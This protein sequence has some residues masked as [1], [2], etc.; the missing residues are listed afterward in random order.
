MILQHPPQANVVG[1][2]HD[3]GYRGV[4]S[5]ED[6]VARTA[7]DLAVVKAR[8]ETRPAGGGKVG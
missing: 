6:W 8:A 5:W 7:F 4:L 1:F 2:M 3:A